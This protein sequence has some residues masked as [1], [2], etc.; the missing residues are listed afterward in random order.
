MADGVVD[1]LPLRLEASKLMTAVPE[2]LG[3]S[4]TSINSPMMSAR[5]E[6]NFGGDVSVPVDDAPPAQARQPAPPPA[7]PPP[8]P[9]PCPPPPPLRFS[10]CTCASAL[11]G[12]EA[13][14][15]D[16]SKAGCTSSAAVG[17]SEIL[18]VKD[19]EGVMIEFKM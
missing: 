13:A 7:R 15:S 5:G 18:V 14:I 10:T 2:T 6:H 17:A 4:I 3:T 12:P 8:P 1:A 16:V 9:D 11:H 19:G